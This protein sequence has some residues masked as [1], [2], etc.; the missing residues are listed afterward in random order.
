[1][2]LAE[3]YLRDFK[4]FYGEHRFT[5]P[6]EG[7]VA[8]IGPNGAG[9]TTL[10]EAIEWCLFSP[11]EIVS[12]EIPT[13]GKAA[14]PCVRVILHDPRED[15]RYVIERQLRRSSATALVYREDQP[16]TPLVQGSRQVSEYVARHLIGLDHRAFV[17]TF[18]TRQKE[19]SFFGSLKET[20]RRR[21]VGRLLGLETIRR[22]QQA[23]A[24]ERSTAR[25]QANVFAIQYQ[26][27]SS[28]RDFAAELADADALVAMRE[29]DVAAAE[30][31]L[32]V[33][34]QALIEAQDR[35]TALQDLERQDRDLRL[36]IERL[37]GDER[38]AQARRDAAQDAL[39]RLDESARLRETL[40]PIAAG[41]PEL[42]AE[43][44]WHEAER[45]RRRQAEQLNASIARAQKTLEDVTSRIRRTVEQ[46]DALD[47]AGWSWRSADN[48]DPVGAVQRLIDVALALD[49]DR[50]AK[51]AQQLAT[52]LSLAQRRDQEHTK[53]V[54]YQNWFDALEQ[55]HAALLA[56]GDPQD[57]LAQARHERDAALA[58]VQEA[59]ASLQQ[60]RQAIA[61][62]Q[63]IIANLQASRLDDRCPTCARPFRPGEIELTL[64]ALSDQV[65]M[66][67][68]RIAIMAEQQRREE[69]RAKEA[70]KAETAAQQ[71]QQELAK[72]A[73]RLEDG[74]KKIAEQREAWEAA[75]RACAEALR[76]CGIETE[77]EPAMVE[78]AQA[79]AQRYGR[80]AATIPVLQELSQRAAQAL[81]DRR[82]AEEA[83]AALGPIAYDAAAHQ[84]S[85]DALAAA[86][87]AVARIFQIDREL[88]QRPEREAELAAALADLDHF[89]E[90]RARLEAQRAA[91]GFD[92]LALERAQQAAQ[93]A[94]EAERAALEQRHLAHERHRQATHQRERLL[95]EHQRINELAER[96]SASERQADLLDQMYREFTAFEQFVAM[97]MAPQLA[98]HTSELVR[99][100]T[101]GKYDRVEFNE[102]YGIEVFDGVD[103]KFP[104]EEFSGGER[105]VIALCARLALSR[106]IGSMAHRPP[107]F[108]V[109]DEVFGALDRDRRSAV[110]ETL[111]ALAGTA[112][113]F[114]QLFIISHVEDVR[115]SPIF[116]EIW[117]VT[118][119]ADGISRL[120]NLA[121]TGGIEDL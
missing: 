55:Q 58:A 44:R 74:R 30:T 26:E 25:Q 56:E 59:K 39:A 92:P 10:F 106:L 32:A 95:E 20:E 99:A 28:G 23:I 61:Q 104:M 16:E 12:D 52:C 31:H 88:A 90:K 8:I 121:E 51:Y 41:E 36:E 87:D 85:A 110:L 86:R 78:A 48:A 46:V 34:S 4:Q 72:L 38:A 24:D 47:I 112:D 60:A 108:L 71:R 96:A 66:Q 22:A 49:A 62:Y 79:Q 73:G 83:L 82:E 84:R 117:R 101:E 76:A 57:A 27:Q 50:V 113:A 115:A 75:E 81:V 109:L 13:R 67:E 119:T 118:E 80:V 15:V 65:E 40:V 35:L 6:P 2:I 69:Q 64:A 54:N 45:E 42:L 1:M 102:N 89:T 37:A 100:I 97:Q 5:P 9:K 14:Q 3:L 120:E 7:V 77:P 114:H 116:S 33:V 17:S 70:E 11:R 103:E 21:E 94:S 93:E 63:G 18:F 91:L 68:Q 43:V 53:L 111:G 19:L 105:D 29:V 98:D 107:G